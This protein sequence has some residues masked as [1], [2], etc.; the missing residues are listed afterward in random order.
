MLAAYSIASETATINHHPHIPAAV[1][2]AHLQ[3]QHQ[4]LQHHLNKQQVQSH[5][6]QA[7]LAANP[8]TG[9]P[10]AALAVIAAAK[11]VN[12]QPQQVKTYGK[13]VNYVE[14]SISSSLIT[15]N[16]SEK[17]NKMIY[18]KFCFVC[19]II[20]CCKNELVRIFELHFP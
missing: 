13:N 6:H 17:K 3:H 12:S 9:N 4:Q 8:I 11:N 16:F 5:H 1:A 20:D 14:F 2:A 7:L 19:K 18:R 10:S 15:E